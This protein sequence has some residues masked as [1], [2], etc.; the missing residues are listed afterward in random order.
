MTPERAKELL[1]EFTAFANGATL[2]I[3]GKGMHPPCRW[4]DMDCEPTWGDLTE[5]RV[6]PEPREGWIVPSNFHEQNDGCKIQGCIKVR[7]VLN[8]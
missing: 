1:P 2:Q 3:R 4:V 7:E 8:D 5:Y 6:K